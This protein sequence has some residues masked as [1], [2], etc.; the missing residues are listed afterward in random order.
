MQKKLMAVAV[1]GALAVPAV[2]VAQSSV[3]VSGR[4]TMEYGR[5]DQ[6]SNRPSTDMADNPGGSNVRFRGQESLGGGLS[7]W[8][9]C[10]SSADVRGVDHDGF[11]T[12]NSA[13]GFRGGFGNVFIGKWDTPMKRAL[14]LGRVGA[15]STGILGMSFIGFGGSGGSDVSGEGNSVNRQRWQRRE[16]SLL[17][18]ETPKFGG[19]QAMGAL[20]DANTATLAVNGQS[21]AKPRLFSLVGTYDMGPL[22]VGLGYERHNEMGGLGNPAGDLDDRAWGLGIGYTFRSVKVG[23]TWLDAKYET[24]VN[25]E[26]KKK[27]WTL[28]ADW[29]LPGPHMVSVQYAKARDT[30][31]NGGNIGG[32]GGV[33]GCATVVAGVAGC[34]DTGADAWSL[35]YTYRFSKRT[36]TRLGYIRV[37]NDSR[38][39]TNRLGSTGSVANGDSVDGWAL[40]V[41]H[42]F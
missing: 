20:T 29:S 25:A 33:T 24:G 4:I 9:Q 11:C 28:G 39:N 30:Q 34:H 26:T 23:F 21:N 12:R 1:A 27:T 22:Q 18:Y 2:A 7:A 16:S 36:T 3:S 6:G 32:N 15:E 17:T 8:F 38:T 5:A 35:G 10:E 13:V 41:K 42:D 31:G 40:L 37:D 19:F 14:N